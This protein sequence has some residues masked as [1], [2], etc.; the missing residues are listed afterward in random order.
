MK[1]LHEKKIDDAKYY[2]DLWDKDKNKRPFYDAVRIRALIEPVEDGDFVLD[3]GAGVYGGCQY[4]SEHT[5]IKAYL[6]C[7]DQSYTA[8]D[9]VKELCPEIN[10]R[11]GDVNQLPYSDGFFDV[12]IA[13]EIIEHLEN[14]AAF[15][16]ELKRVTKSGGAV[17]LSTVN[18]KCINAINHGE[19]VEHLWEFEPEDLLEMFGDGAEFSYVGDYQFIFYGKLS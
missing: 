6:Y 12:V 10:Y 3:V 8:R 2:E 15:V 16:N 19:Y 18:T 13:G 9:V 17:T 1:R 5:D 7:I 4:I 14:P 11:L